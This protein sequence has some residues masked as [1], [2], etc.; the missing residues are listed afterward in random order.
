[1]KRS[2][3]LLGVIAFAMFTTTLTAQ[4]GGMNIGRLQANESLQVGTASESVVVQSDLVALPPLTNSEILRIVDP[5]EG[6]IVYATDS[7]ILLV[8]DGEKWRRA[9]GQN[10]SY[11]IIPVPCGAPFIDSRDGTSYNTVEIGTQCWMAENL[12]YLPSVVGPATGSETA[13][14]ETTS[15]Y[16]VY[17]YDG[18]VVAEAKATS[19]YATYGV[20]YNWPAAMD[21]SAS[22]E[23][24]PSGVQGACP[25]GWHLPSDAEWTV[26]TDLL[27]GLN[28][29][30]GKMKEQETVHWKSPNTGATNESGFTGLPGGYRNYLNGSFSIV[31]YSGY[32]WSAMEVSG[33]YAWPRCLSSDNAL[34]SRSSYKKSNGFSVRCLRDSD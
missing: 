32:W 8:F 33:Q 3:L 23:A 31:G 28:Y 15:Y 2:A 25:D 12:K 29:S 30:G 11:L 9:D 4:N 13:G 22:S 20:L 14:S 19:N 17:G 1:M 27:G 18:I 6:S 21:G 10:D 24:N 34:V 26:L 16:Y 7:D 5:A